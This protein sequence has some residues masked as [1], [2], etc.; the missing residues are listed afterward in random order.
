MF[1]D[2]PVLAGERNRQAAKPAG[3]STR[4]G[5]P[6][7]HAPSDADYRGLTQGAPLC[8]RRACFVRKI[9]R[10]APKTRRLQLGCCP[11]RI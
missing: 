1:I 3:C 8:L 5:N 9:S 10:P 7:S 6:I 11:S 4:P 2:A